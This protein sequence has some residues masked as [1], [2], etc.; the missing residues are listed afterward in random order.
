M[1]NSDTTCLIFHV[2]REA[3]HIPDKASTVDGLHLRELLLGALR[4]ISAHMALAAFCAHQ[5]ARA[6]QAESLG[7]RLMGFE[8]EFARFGFTRHCNLLLS[9]KIKSG[10]LTF[11]RRRKHLADLLFRFSPDFCFCRGFSFVFF[12][13]GRFSWR[14]HHEHGSAFHHRGLLDHANVRQRCG[15]LF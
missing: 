13:G 4:S 1:K 2:R 12:L 3:L 7:S 10:L 11:S 8:L 15:N 14:Q 9:D 6:R 5:F